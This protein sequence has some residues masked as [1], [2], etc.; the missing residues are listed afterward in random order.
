MRPGPLPTPRG[1]LLGCALVAVVA[2]LN[3]SA[4]G[5]DDDPATADPAETHSAQSK[6]QAAR[7]AAPAPRATDPAGAEPCPAELAAFVGSLHRLRRQLA[8]GLSYEQYAARTKG[9]RGSYD[10]I[11]VGR[12]TFGCLTK[13]GSTAERSLNAYIDAVNAWGQCLADV[14]CTTASIEP[15]LQRKWRLASRFLAQ[16]R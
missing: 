15:V 10:R 13:T 16:A 3:L 12:L 5:G 9:L 4:C 7:P 2:A 6:P 14:A 1:P 8:V 11:P